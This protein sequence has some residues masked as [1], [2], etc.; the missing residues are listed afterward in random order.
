MRTGFSRVKVNEFGWVVEVDLGL[1]D[2][3]GWRYA[4]SLPKNP[5]EGYHTSDYSTKDSTREG[6]EHK[7]HKGKIM[8]P[9]MCFVFLAVLSPQW[10]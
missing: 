3:N 4:S 8:L 7:M 2:P 1:T 5:P 9:C 10:V 6:G